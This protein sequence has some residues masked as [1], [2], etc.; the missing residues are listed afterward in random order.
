MAA[1]LKMVM[2]MM[3]RSE[4]TRDTVKETSSKMWDGGK[5]QNIDDNENDMTKRVSVV[6]IAI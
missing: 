1:R 5:H 6:F 3:T 2:M 4:V